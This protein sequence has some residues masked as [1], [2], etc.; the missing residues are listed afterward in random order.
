MA[1]KNM[2]VGAKLKILLSVEQ[3][4][5]NEQLFKQF[6]IYAIVKFQISMGICWVP[7]LLGCIY[8]RKSGSL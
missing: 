4:D 7:P 1:Q 2:A 6:L 3:C 5:K 8:F